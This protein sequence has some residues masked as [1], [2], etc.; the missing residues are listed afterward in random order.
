LVA[1]NATMRHVML[2]GRVAGMEQSGAVALALVGGA[3]PLRVE[4]ALFEEMLLGWRRQ[5][6]SRRL[7]GS[8]IDGRE[9]T[10]RRFQVF[11]E[12]WPWSWRAEQLERWVAE[13]GWAHSTVRCYQGA[14]AAF[15]SY[16]TDPRYGWVA[17]CEQ[18][19]GARPSQNRGLPGHREAE[20]ATSLADVCAARGRE[21]RQVGRE[22]SLPTSLVG[23]L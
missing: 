11:A 16:V 5:Q 13:G 21:V 10:V 15:C 19:V 6:L 22:N 4:S 17:E 9:R 23:S 12:G 1:F 20:G 18:R 14:V 3:T 7:G 2:A 8:L